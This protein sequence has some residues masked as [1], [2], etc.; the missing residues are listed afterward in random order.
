V[1]QVAFKLF[2]LRLLSLWLACN[3]TF[4]LFIVQFNLLDHFLLVML[5]LVLVSLGYR[6]VG[7][8]VGRVGCL[9]L[10]LLFGAG[11]GGS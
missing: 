11:G 4:V 2:R 7:T 10:L 5:G 6:L 3:F 9:L 1:V 8:A